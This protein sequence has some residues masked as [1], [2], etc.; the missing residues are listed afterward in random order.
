L[1][2]RQRDR[3]RERKT[4][5]KK[6]R[7]RHAFQSV[8][9]I[10]EIAGTLPPAH[11]STGDGGVIEVTEVDTRHMDSAEAA[12]DVQPRRST[13]KDPSI[14]PK[15]S[16]STKVKD[17]KTPIINKKKSVP[18]I[19]EK[20]LQANQELLIRQKIKRYFNVDRDESN[21]ISMAESVVYYY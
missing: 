18:L 1:K 7:Q 3:K 20:R 15:K 8:F 19:T 9:A 2:E 6:E 4:E 11:D 21:S 13:L 12:I 17:N 10:K 14:V 5:R 16:M